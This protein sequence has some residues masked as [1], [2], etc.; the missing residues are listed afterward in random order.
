[1][2]YEVVYVEMKDNMMNSKG[3]SV[4]SSIKLRDA[5]VK[6]MLG[7][8][9]STTNATTDTNVYE[10]R[11]DG[12]LSFS[13]SGSKV[14]YANQLS[15]DLGNITHLYPNAVANMRTRMKSLG[16]KEYTYLPLWM[17][18][19]Q[20]DTLGPIGYVMA[21]PICY[22]KP[23]TSARLK[24][25]IEDKKI[26]LKNIHFTM[27]GYNVSKSIVSPETFTGDGSTTTFELNEIVH[28]QDILVKEGSNIV[29]SGTGVTADHNSLFSGPS[30]LTADGTLRSSDHELGVKLTHDKTN[31]KTTITFTKEVPAEG[32]IIK[33]ERLNDKYLAF[34][35]IGI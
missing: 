29:F 8:R 13:T 10:V 32:T 25:R 24:K 7:P 5:V 31:K 12:G 4:A 35:N 19:Q 27:D 11:T 15:A 30:Y 2:K 1:V 20:V 18:T 28:E 21:V 34:K 22:C 14:R 6:P 16:H 26:E 23:G 33:V 17:R 3:E 9:A